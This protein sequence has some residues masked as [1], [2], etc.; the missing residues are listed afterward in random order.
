MVD[1]LGDDLV[2]SQYINANERQLLSIIDLTPFHDRSTT[3]PTYVERIEP[4]SEGGLN[5]V[6][7]GAVQP[8]DQCLVTVSPSLMAKITPSLPAAYLQGLLDLKSMGLW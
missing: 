4:Q 2:R 8:F 3:A 1:T 5:L 6:V 7:Q